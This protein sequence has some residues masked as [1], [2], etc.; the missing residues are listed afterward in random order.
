L[1]VLVYQL[2]T[3]KHPYKKSNSARTNWLAPSA[4]KCRCPPSHAA[5]SEKNGARRK[6]KI[7]DRIAG[8]LDSIILKSLQKESGERYPS[9]VELA[10]DFE[11]FLN[12][13]AINFTSVPTIANETNRNEKTIAVLPFKFLNLL[14]NDKEDTD[15]NFL[16]LG[17]TDAL[18]TRLSNVRSLTVR[19]RARF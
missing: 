3:G 2:L 11:R 16:G 19:R 7:E 13:Q 9:A 5:E 17:L 6:L 14:P 18:I 15:K 1:G 10:A 4:R 12:G 8:D